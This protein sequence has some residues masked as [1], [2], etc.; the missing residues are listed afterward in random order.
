MEQK[1]KVRCRGIILYKGKLLLVSHVPDKSRYT[2]PGGHLENKENPLECMEREVVEELGINPKIGRLLYVH[3]FVRPESHDIEFFFE[4][5]NG[6]D[7]LDI[8]K[9]TGTHGHELT[10]IHWTSVDENLNILPEK[11]AVDFRKGTLIS[12]QV[13]FI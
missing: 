1:F 10:D 2:L 11:I 3:N 5:L 9:L 13:K 8:E 4:I 12:D 6:E 7:Y